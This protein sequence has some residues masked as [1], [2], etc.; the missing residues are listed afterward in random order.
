MKTVNIKATQGVRNDVPP[1]RFKSGDLVNGVNIDIDETGKTSR[2]KGLRKVL[3]GSDAHS[4]WGND[5]RALYVDSG[6]LYGV[7]KDFVKTTLIAGL[8]VGRRMSYVE[9]AQR[10]YLSNGVDAFVLNGA[11]ASRLGVAVPPMISAATT[12]GELPAGTYGYT[13]TFVRANGQESG[14]PPCAYSVV[15]ANGGLS[16]T[17][18]PVSNDPDVTG[19]NLYITPANG[20]IPYLV[21]T[22]TNAMTTASY[23]ASTHGSLPCVTQFKGP[24]PPGSILGY[25]NGRLY[26]SSGN[27]IYYSDPYNYELT[28]LDENFLQFDARVTIIAPVSDGV[29]VGSDSETIFLKGGDPSEFERVQVSPEASVFGTLTY[30]NPRFITDKGVQ[31]VTPMWATERGICFGGSGGQFVE[32]TSDRY[33]L[34]DVASGSSLYRL[35]SGTSQFLTVFN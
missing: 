32:L 31:G 26:S 9:A 23:S 22:F 33:V 10:I 18:L 35:Q 14:A 20:E 7:S 27:V 3:D 11:T 6:T 17:N 1:E 25:Y 12:Y 19:K 28:T 30:T 16:F 24:L 8:S 5:A 15:P 2:R 13:M 29:F 4:L 21:A 34:P